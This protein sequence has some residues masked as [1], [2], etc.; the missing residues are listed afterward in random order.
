MPGYTQFV[1]CFPGSDTSAMIQT[2]QS[3]LSS[4]APKMPFLNGK[5]VPDTESKQEGRLMFRHADHEIII[6]IVEH[7]SNPQ[8]RV[9]GTYE[10]LQRRGFPITVLRNNILMERAKR[11]VDQD[12]L[13]R[14]V[15]AVQA[16]KVVGGV[17]LSVWLHNMYGDAG[18]HLTCKP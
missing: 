8:L 1:L 16:N 6:S 5:N 11:R 18:K 10:E 17:L 2:I 12:A 4:A 15:L 14:P 3:G 13:V 9:I 7:M